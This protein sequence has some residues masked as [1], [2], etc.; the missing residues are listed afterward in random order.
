ME[1][2]ADKI[3]HQIVMYHV[4]R[5]SGAIFSSRK[6]L[7]HTSVMFWGR[8]SKATSHILCQKHSTQTSELRILYVYCMCLLD[9]YVN[10][11][12]NKQQKMENTRAKQGEWENVDPRTSEIETSKIDYI[13]LCSEFVN[14][15]AEYDNKSQ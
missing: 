8:N 2:L 6:L 13:N 1:S 7:R 5:R 15:L 4:H 10:D 12:V 11:N 3:N 9:E 14:S